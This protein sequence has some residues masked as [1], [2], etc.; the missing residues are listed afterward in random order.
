MRRSL[1]FVVGLLAVVL[2][3]LGGT[4][5]VALSQDPVSPPQC[6][7]GQDNDGDGDQDSPADDGC[8]DAN[9]ASEDSDGPPPP[10]AGNGD[11]DSS[12]EGKRDGDH[13]GGGGDRRRRRASS[14]GRG[15]RGGAVVKPPPV[16]LV[17]S[18]I[19]RIKGVIVRGGVRVQLLTVYGPAGATVRARCF[20]KG[21]PVGPQ[22]IPALTV[23]AVPVPAVP[24]TPLPGTSVPGVRTVS[25]TNFQGRYFRAGHI[26]EVRVTRE[27][28]IGKVTRF[29]IREGKPPLRTELCLV[30]GA[31]PPSACSP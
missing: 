23:P 4:A 9:D 17:P 31:G 13:K 22:D 30:P 5:G 25:L 20:G 7:D 3:T 19:V 29:R 8:E 10:P 15:R 1:L 26:L 24:G 11:G 21:C 12:S 18:P 27:G 28:H 16:R 14:R 2:A 6:S